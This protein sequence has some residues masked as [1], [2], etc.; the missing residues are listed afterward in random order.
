MIMIMSLFRSCEPGLRQRPKTAHLGH[1]LS[2]RHFRYFS[3]T[4]RYGFV[5]V[6]TRDIEKTREELVFLRHIYQPFGRITIL[7]H[8]LEYIY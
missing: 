6:P 5:G 3:N 4:P 2:G 1:I 7:Y 8:A